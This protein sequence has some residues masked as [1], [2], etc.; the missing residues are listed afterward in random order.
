MNNTVQDV[1]LIN[2]NPDTQYNVHV[3]ATARTQT[4]KSNERLFKTKQFGRFSVCVHM[5]CPLCMI[6][7]H[8]NFTVWF[9]EEMCC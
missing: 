8:Q 9:S 5:T 2:L 4:A 1:Y 7:I 6:T 3:V